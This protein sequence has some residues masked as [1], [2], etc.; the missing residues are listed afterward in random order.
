MMEWFDRLAQWH[1]ARRGIVVLPRTFI[2][3]AIGYGQAIKL[4]T[5]GD[6]ST[7][8]RRGARLLQADHPQQFP[9]DRPLVGSH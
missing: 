2:G 3:L 4:A 6:F 5:D 8:R 7:Y 1:L 9:F